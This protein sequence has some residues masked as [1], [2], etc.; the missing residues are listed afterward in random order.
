MLTATTYALEESYSL[1]STNY[2]TVRAA[3]SLYCRVRPRA[4][5]LRNWSFQEILPFSLQSPCACSLCVYDYEQLC[6]ASDAG[7]TSA[8]SHYISAVACE[9]ARAAVHAAFCDSTLTTPLALSHLR[10][11]RACK[12]ITPTRYN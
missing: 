4:R 11:L 8:N 10:L 6:I 2:L 1:N 9:A 5:K 7:F 3:P 12:Q